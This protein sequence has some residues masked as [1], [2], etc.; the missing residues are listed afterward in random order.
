M[1]RARA[2]VIIYAAVSHG[3]LSRGAVERIERSQIRRM[4]MTDTIEPPAE[5]LGHHFEIISVGTALRP[6]HLFHPSS[7]QR[8]HAL[9]RREVALKLLSEPS[10]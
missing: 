2:Q 1:L 7:D 5:P 4:F 8:Q 6:G 9:S 3:V 10:L